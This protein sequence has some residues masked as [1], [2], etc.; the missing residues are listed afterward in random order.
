MELFVKLFG[1]VYMKAVSQNA[2]ENRWL[3]P[4]R[5]AKIRF[6][7]LLCADSTNQRL[8]AT[9]AASRLVE[10]SLTVLEDSWESARIRCCSRSDQNNNY[11]QCKVVL[12]AEKKQGKCQAP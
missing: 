4:W 1:L 10:D 2:A 7:P 8:G 9:L 11:R 3:V 5:R 6:S 12:G